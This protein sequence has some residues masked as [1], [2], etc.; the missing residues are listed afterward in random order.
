MNPLA[1]VEARATSWAGWQGQ[2]EI[3]NN[4]GKKLRGCWGWQEANGNPTPKVLGGPPGLEG[5]DKKP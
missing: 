4:L 3:G 1:A 5:G 2:H